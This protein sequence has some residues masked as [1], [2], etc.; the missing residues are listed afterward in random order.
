MSNV[1]LSAALITLAEQS[2]G[3]DIDNRDDEN[4]VCEGKVYGF[5]PSSL[6]TIIATVSGLLAAFLLPII[7]AI[8]DYTKHRKLMGGIFAFLLITIQ[9][10]QIGTVEATWFPMAILQA[11]N[12]FFYQAV[13]LAAYAYL[14]E[15]SRAVGEA[16]MT[17]YSSRF[18]MWMFGMEALYLIIVVG[19]S[20]YFGF[21]DQYTAHVG[22]AFDVFV[23][24]FFYTL[25]FYFFTNKEPRRTLPEGTS[26]LSAG[27]KQVFVTT[28]GIVKHY[29][30]TL[31]WF[32]LAIVFAEAGKVHHGFVL[33]ISSF[34]LKKWILMPKSFVFFFLKGVNSFTTVAVTFLVVHALSWQFEVA[35]PWRWLAFLQQR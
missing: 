29:P 7:G 27:F 31:T 25:G 4:Y 6:I 16:T 28:K 10:I 21:G 23:S 12:G 11:I 3:C 26:F 35:L 9:A 14:P 18:Y 1:F 13:T 2:L 15:I 19:V 30:S 32:L 20:I 22:Q 34:R 17:I 24:G 8:V 5:R 33:C